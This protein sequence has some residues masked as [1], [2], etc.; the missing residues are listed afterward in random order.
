MVCGA[1]KKHVEMNPVIE[2]GIFHPCSLLS[3]F[4]C[5]D[6]FPSIFFAKVQFTTTNFFNVYKKSKQMGKSVVSDW[7]GHLS[8]GNY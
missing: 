8:S 2:F 6:N 1:W 4:K 3:S 7:I 5:F